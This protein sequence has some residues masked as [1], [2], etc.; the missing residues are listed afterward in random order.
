MYSEVLRN[1]IQETRPYSRRVYMTFYDARSEVKFL[2]IFY[3]DRVITA[4]AQ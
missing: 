4:H 1:R 2:T 3:T